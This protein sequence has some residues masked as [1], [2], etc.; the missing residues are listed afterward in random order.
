M[1]YFIYITTKKK[2]KE[3]KERKKKRRKTVHRYFLSRYSFKIVTIK[4]NFA[5]K[6][7]F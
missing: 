2:K 1:K 6:K 5:R 3:E 4:L 7:K